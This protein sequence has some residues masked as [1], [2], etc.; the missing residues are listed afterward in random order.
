MTKLRVLIVEYDQSY[1]LKLKSELSKM[2]HTVLDIVDNSASALEVIYVESPDLIIMA[3]HIHGKLN[4]LELGKRLYKHNI[5]IIYTTEQQ[6]EKNYQFAQKINAAAYLVKPISSSILQSSIDNI[7]QNAYNSSP[8]KNGHAVTDLNEEKESI[9]IKYNNNLKRVAFDEIDFI[10]SEGN[11]SI[12]HTSD[13]KYAV[14]ISLR[15]IQLELPD[16][17]F[18][19]IHQRYVV[20]IQKISNI[21][22]SSAKVFLGDSILPLGRTYKSDL[23]ERFRYLK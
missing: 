13:R 5:P 11:Y 1:A 10:Q 15:R 2:G 12:I 23:L 16:T 21:E 14:K 18:A 9:F 8:S 6:N 19:Q 20:P 7:L 22:L 4:G 3:I 17:L